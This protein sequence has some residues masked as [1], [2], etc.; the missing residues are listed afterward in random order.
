MWILVDNYDS[1]SD[2]LLH[3]LLQLNPNT[4][5][6]K[7][8]E[9]SVE[10]ISE[11]RPERIILSPGPKSPMHAGITLDLIHAFH[12]FTPI[13]GICLGHQAIGTYFGAR[14]DKAMQPRHGKVSQISINNTLPI[15]SGLP[16]KVPVMRYH[17]LVISEL[18]NTNLRSIA[19]DKD[20]AIMAL[21]HNYYP[22]VG[23]QFH[24]ESVLTPHGATMLKNWAS[25]QY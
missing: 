13:L 8:D 5:L 16:E 25:H 20:G 21:A 12:A 9:C 23:L 1:F 15:F 17:S 22:C 4:I 14:L 3:Y 24:P 11:M 6:L 19:H 7:N 18:D 2:M 10:E